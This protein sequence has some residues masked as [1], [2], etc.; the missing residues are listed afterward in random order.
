MGTETQIFN[1]I[2]QLLL[3]S[4]GQFASIG[5]AMFTGFAT[6]MIVWFGVK[7][8]LTAGEVVGGF[9]FG[10]FAEFLLSDRLRLRDDQLLQHADPRLRSRAFRSLSPTNR[11]I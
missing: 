2:S 10:K 1:Y 6:I 8:A 9:H 11:S 5:Q 3:Q 7:S 4:G